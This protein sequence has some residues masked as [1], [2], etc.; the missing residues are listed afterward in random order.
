MATASVSRTSQ[1][2]RTT[3]T[4]TIISTDPI[5]KCKTMDGFGFYLIWF[6]VIAIITWLVLYS[7]KPQFVLKTD[8]SG[9]VDTAKV[10]LWSVV[11]GLVGIILI[12]IVR[13]ITALYKL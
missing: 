2:I 8:D 12:W 10:L 13:K 4:S 3:P 1:A 6:L 7:L 9:D 5:P 11:I